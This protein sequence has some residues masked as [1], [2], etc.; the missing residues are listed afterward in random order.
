M[1]CLGFLTDDKLAREAAVYGAAGVGPQVVW[2][3]GV[4]ASTAVGIAINLLTGWAGKP[5]ALYLPYDANSGTE[6]PQARLPYV[7]LDGPR[8]HYPQSDI[9]EPRLVA[10]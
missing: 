9:C 10:A 4:L 5:G 8:P 7:G 3:N 2:A 6:A 1:T